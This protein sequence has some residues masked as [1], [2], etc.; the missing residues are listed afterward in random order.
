MMQSSGLRVAFTV[1]VVALIV[2]FVALARNDPGVDDRDPDPPQSTEV[3]E[4]GGD[5]VP[6]DTA[7]VVDPDT[8]PVTS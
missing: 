4:G 2:A 7:V 3:V 6:P 1:I 5:L 8:V